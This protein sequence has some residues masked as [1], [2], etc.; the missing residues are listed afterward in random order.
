MYGGGGGGEEEPTDAFEV[1]EACQNTME[2][3]TRLTLNTGDTNLHI[4]HKSEVAASASVDALQILSTSE[5][6]SQVLRTVG[7]WV[8]QQRY[9]TDAGFP[10]ESCLFSCS[11]RVQLAVADR[12]SI[13]LISSSAVR[14]ERGVKGLFVGT[15]AP[16]RSYQ[17]V[18]V[19]LLP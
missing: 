8:A 19:W 17:I 6:S 2:Q 16:R 4:L 11:K 1:D 15:T 5:E 13:L 12:G 3:G 10:E 9:E 14:L 18:I 7:D